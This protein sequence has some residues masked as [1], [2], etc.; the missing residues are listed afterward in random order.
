M[1]HDNLK[2]YLVTL[3]GI[4]TSSSQ[5]LDSRDAQNIVSDIFIALL[6]NEMPAD[7]KTILT[8]RCGDIIRCATARGGMLSPYHDQMLNRLS[9]IS[10]ISSALMEDEG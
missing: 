6:L 5:N 9:V 10:R 7:R 4:N 3:Y 8:Q 2:D 1:K